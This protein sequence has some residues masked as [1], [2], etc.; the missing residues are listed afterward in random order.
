M[1]SK[2][3]KPSKNTRLT[4]KGEFPTVRYLVSRDKYEV[5]AGNRLGGAK[6]YRRWFKTEAEA[7]G[8]AETLKIRLKNEGLSGF[9]LSREDQVDAEKAL[10]ILDGRGSLEQACEF[11]IRYLGTNGSDLNVA[12]LV[13]EFLIHKD[14]Q[15]LLGE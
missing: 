5:D 6:K 12:Q 11:Y 7:R 9:K 14:R 15:Q 8:H 2:T 4:P 13:D 10:K 1:A 3:V